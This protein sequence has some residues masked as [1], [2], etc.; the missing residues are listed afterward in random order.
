DEDERKI[1]DLYAYTLFNDGVLRRYDTSHEVYWLPH[2]SIPHFFVE[3][4][5]TATLR[6]RPYPIPQHAG[7]FL[8]GCYG[9]DWQTPYRAVRQGGTPR[10]GV[11]SYSD[12]YAPKL[13]AEIAYAEA[14]GWS[15]DK[16]RHEL[17]WPRPMRGA[18]PVG[19]DPR[20][21]DTTRAWWWRSRDELLAHY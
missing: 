5:E 16:Y 20:T 6:G 14:H 13:A 9:E 12:R 11:T 3:R 7:A 8:A 4:L 18:G 19:D 1:G 21:A 2:S 10:E 17:P 15:R